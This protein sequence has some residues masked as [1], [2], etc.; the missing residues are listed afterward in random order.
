MIRETLKKAE[1]LN[2]QIVEQPMDLS[3]ELFQL[4]EKS[5]LL[6]DVNH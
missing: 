6:R 5:Q 4:M 1:T 2:S 3:Y